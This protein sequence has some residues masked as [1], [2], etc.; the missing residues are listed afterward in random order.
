MLS[1]CPMSFGHIILRTRGAEDLGSSPGLL[2]Y[3]PTRLRSRFNGDSTRL[4]HDLDGDTQVR[5]HVTS[6]THPAALLPVT[7]VPLHRPGMVGVHFH[8]SAS[9]GTFVVHFLGKRGPLRWREAPADQLTWFEPPN[10]TVGLAFSILVRGSGEARLEAIDTIT[11]PHQGGLPVGGELT[12]QLAGSL[13]PTGPISWPTTVSSTVL[14]R[15]QIEIAGHLLS[16]ETPDWSAVNDENRSLQLLIHGFGYADALLGSVGGS[17]TLARLLIDWSNAHPPRAHSTTVMAWNDM[18]VSRRT[19]AILKS[20]DALRFRDHALIFL[21]HLTEMLAQHAGWLAHPRNYVADHDHGLYADT[22]LEFAARALYFHP[23]SRRW[24]R[25]AQTR[26]NATARSIIDPVEGTVREHSPSYVAAV[27]EL[28][29]ERRRNRLPDDLGNEIGDRFARTL[30]ALTTP[31]GRLIPWGDTSLDQASSESRSVGIFGFPRTG[32]SISHHPNSTV[33]LNS[34]FHSRN[35]RHADELSFLF[36]D[37][38]GPIVF[39]AGLPGYGYGT[40]DRNY[41]ESALAHSGVLVEHNGDSQH[42]PEPFGSGIVEPAEAGLWHVLLAWNPGLTEMRHHRWIVHHPDLI[43]VVDL[44][45]GQDVRNVTRLLHIAPRRVLDLHGKDVRIG[46]WL[47]APDL[48]RPCKP[49]VSESR[50]FPT[51]G[52]TDT[53]SVLELHDWGPGLR[54][55][56]IRRTNAQLEIVGIDASATP[57]RLELAL[58]L[59]DGRLLTASARPALAPRRL[60]LRVATEMVL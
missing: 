19:M 44:V 58:H 38:D 52:N 35:H 8:G 55:L 45:T 17:D 59:S 9:S 26:F 53:H 42:S 57:G 12:R 28:I 33:A 18:A 14:S 13:F 34:S 16:T 54:A 24:L 23:L 49:E 4:F 56:S 25:R 6:S 50:H 3:R 47:L 32:W 37:R 21:P 5:V 10:G 60:D 43:G 46:D 22:A 1:V 40:S 15:E 36:Y 29:T 30:S 7:E 2:V 11:P 31:E 39:E 41:A 20:I 51:P 48:V 27:A